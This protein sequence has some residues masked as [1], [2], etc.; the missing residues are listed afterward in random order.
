MKIL[1]FIP[2]LVR[3]GAERVAIELANDAARRGHQVA[4]VAAVRNS[5]EL[6]PLP[7]RSDVELRYV[8]PRGGVRGAQL[9]LIPWTIA[10]RQW[11]FGQDVIHCHLWLGTQFGA[12]LQKIRGRRERPVIVETYHAVGMP[13]PRHHR[14]LHALLLHGRDATAFMAEDPY[15]NRY[16]AARPGQLFRT[17]PNGVS[18]PRPVSPSGDRAAAGIPHNA[19]LVGSI[20]RLVNERRPDLLMQV[21]AGIAREIDRAHLLLAGEGPERPALEARACAS[22]LQERVH[23]PGLVLDAAEPLGIIDLYVTVAVGSTVGV[24]ALEAALSGLPVLAVQLLPEY[25]A[26]G[27]DWIWSSADPAEVAGRAVEL[28]REPAKLRALAERQRVHAGAHYTAEAMSDA[29]Q[30]FYTDA[31]ARRHE[32]FMA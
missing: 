4:M 19:L 22:E 32:R 31:L 16:R 12:L 20:G 17:I 26:T 10:N 15:W 13:I 8:H 28:L 11:L 25:R 7:L 27:G 2:S 18:A 29:Q 1:H 5:P 30:R 21:F 24:A 9:R 23:M 3:G 6:M 14:A